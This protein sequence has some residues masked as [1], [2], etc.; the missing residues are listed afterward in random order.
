[1]RF[2][3]ILNNKIIKE[4]SSLEE[5]QSNLQKHQD[6]LDKQEQKKSAKVKT[7]VK[8]KKNILKLVQ[9]PNICIGLKVY[10]SESK[11]I[12][13]I[14]SESDNLWFTRKSNND[15]DQIPTPWLKENFEQKYID[16]LFI[17]GDDK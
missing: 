7:N 3:L 2:C 15:N 5:A 8:S 1:M 13:E 10:N 9:I 12:G 6:K 14:I 4:Y 17:V 16:E 11:F